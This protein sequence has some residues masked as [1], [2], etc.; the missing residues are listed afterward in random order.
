MHR[1]RETDIICYIILQMSRRFHELEIV[2]ELLPKRRR[3]VSATSESSDNS[4]E[5]FGL[6]SKND[7][8]EQVSISFCL[9]KYVNFSELLSKYMNV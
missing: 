6:S 5:T 2:D 9:L 7:I 3:S 1:H 8:P 4:K